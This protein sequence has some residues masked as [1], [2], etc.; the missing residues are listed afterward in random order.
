MVRGISQ[1][2][3]PA[4]IIGPTELTEVTFRSQRRT[5]ADAPRVPKKL[6]E[7]DVE[8][9]GLAASTLTYLPCQIPESGTFADNVAGVANSPQPLW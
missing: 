3:S 1:R 2:T 5:S 4:S 9:S 7:P 6:P 8:R